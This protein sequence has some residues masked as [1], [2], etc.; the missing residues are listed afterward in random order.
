[1]TPTEIGTK[2]VDRLRDGRYAEIREMFAPNLRPLVT[3][4]S[5]RV[6]WEAEI[7]RQGAVTGIG[8]P[9]AEPAGANGTGLLRVPV[10]FERGAAAVLASIA[11]NLSPDGAGDGAPDRAAGVGADRAAGVASDAAS[12]AGGAWLTSLQIAPAEAAQPMRPWEPP[13]YADPSALREREVT[14]GSGP[15][16]V[17]GILTEP[18]TPGP[19]LAVVMLSG[20]GPNDRDETIGRNKPFKDLAWGL[21][22]RGVATLRFDKVTYAHGAE[23]AADPH[24]TVQEEYVDHAVAA[25]RMLAEQFGRVFVLGHS[26]GGSVAPRVAAAAPAVAGLV[27]VAGGAQPAHWA[28]VRQFRYLASLDPA[29]EAAAGPLIETITRQAE[30]VDSPD[31]SASTPAAELPFGVPGAY[32]LDL[33]DYDAAASAA[34]IDRPM[35]ILQGGR[36]YQVTVADDLARW[37]AALAGRPD[38]T[39]RVYDADDHLFF[40]GE[41]PSTPAAYEPAQH[42]DPAVVTDIATWLA[43]P[44]D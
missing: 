37:Q 32:W 3:T 38:V 14:V 22:A 26:E 21:A 18:V 35:L 15:L 23:A 42:V 8:T 6:A 44:A 13:A 11:G 31:L 25:V 36:D 43:T 41:G 40:A 27:I 20:S 12:G 4:E 19:D 2:L 29:T 30:A 17:P 24:F 34:K 16:S 1:M 39:F 10:T 33:R 5:L 28:A 9:V 7:A